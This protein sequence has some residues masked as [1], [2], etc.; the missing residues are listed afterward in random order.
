MEHLQASFV[1]LEQLKTCL[2]QPYPP[3]ACE[4]SGVISI[5]KQMHLQGVGGGGAA[6][7]S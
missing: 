7:F 2:P 4:M 3:I 6:Q 5:N 1:V